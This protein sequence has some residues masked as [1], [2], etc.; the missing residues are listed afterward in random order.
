MLTEIARPYVGMR[1]AE[2]LGVFSICDEMAE[3][4]EGL[5]AIV[6]G[7]GTDEPCP[8]VEDDLDLDAELDAALSAEFDAIIG[9]RT[10]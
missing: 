8:K 7:L 2:P 1:I 6:A 5:K 3:F 4:M 9:L 10:E